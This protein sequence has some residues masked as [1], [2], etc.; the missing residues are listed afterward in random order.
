MSDRSPRSNV[1]FPFG[2]AVGTPERGLVGYCERPEYHRVRRRHG[3]R[4]V[5]R[6]PD[7]SHGSSG[8]LVHRYPASEGAPEAEPEHP[9]EQGDSRRGRDGDVDLA[10]SSRVV[11][12]TPEAM[13]K[14]AWLDFI[15]RELLAHKDGDFSSAYHF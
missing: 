3:R 7:P 2:L 4:Q 15:R 9:G 1:A 14:P 11:F 13:Q 6:V 10:S 8:R 12:V 5:D